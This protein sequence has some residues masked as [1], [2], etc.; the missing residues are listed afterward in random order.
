[1]TPFEWLLLGA[2]GTQLLTVLQMI[3][4]NQWVKEVADASHG[5]TNNSFTYTY[6]TLPQPVTG[7][8]NGADSSASS[9]TRAS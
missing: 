6:G 3:R 9:F 4:T 5:H 2:L 7:E 1:M 8:E